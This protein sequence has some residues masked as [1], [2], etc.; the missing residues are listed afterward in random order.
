MTTHMGDTQEEI[1]AAVEEA[2]G[3]L[4]AKERKEIAEVSVSVQEAV[5][6]VNARVEG[7]K[8]EDEDLTQGEDVEEPQNFESARH[9]Q[10]N[11]E[12]VAARRA[13]SHGEDPGKALKQA[14]KDAPDELKS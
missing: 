5:N 6:R 8:G 13:E 11:R 12:H 4:T 10:G 14:Q 1:D 9:E 7:R 2:G 3:E